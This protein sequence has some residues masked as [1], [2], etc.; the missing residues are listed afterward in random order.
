MCAH[1]CATLHT[2]E[3]LCWLLLAA[4]PPHASHRRRFEDVQQLHLIAYLI[5]QGERVEDGLNAGII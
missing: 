1:L 2:L 3:A 4:L 5:L